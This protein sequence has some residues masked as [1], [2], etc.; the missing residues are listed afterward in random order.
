MGM[1][2][3]FRDKI[4][5]ELLDDNSIWVTMILKKITAYKTFIFIDY[6]KV[7]LE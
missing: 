2:Y 6:Y 5:D 3:M 1:S 7:N 4:F